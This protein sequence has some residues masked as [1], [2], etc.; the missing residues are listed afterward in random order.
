MNRIIIDYLSFTIK[1]DAKSPVVFGSK[2][3]HKFIAWV[4]GMDIADFVDCGKTR[5]YEK[6]YVC[7]DITIK[8]PFEGKEDKQGFNVVMTGNGCRH[9]ESLQLGADATKI[10]KD[11]FIKLRGLTKYGL[12]VN[13]TR[14]DNALDDFKGYLDL[15]K[16]EESMKNREYVSRF[17]VAQAIG[18]NGTVFVRDSKYVH[19]YKHGLKGRTIYFGSRNSDSFCRF[20]DKKT[21]QMQKYFNDKVRMQEL[22]AI[23]H[24][25]RMEFEFAD[26]TA[27]KMVNAFIDSEDYSKFFGAYVNGMLRFVDGDSSR[28]ERCASKS[29]WTK[30]IGTLKRTSLAIGDYKPLTLQKCR[31]YVYNNL[32]GPISVVMQSDGVDFFLKFINDTALAKIKPKHLALIGTMQEH[33]KDLCS[34]DLWSVLRP[35]VAI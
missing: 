1:V 5:F 21:E 23:E 13:I 30:F 19:N 16:I 11:F 2:L 27:L 7:N 20:Y 8:V 9:F 25:V 31:N 18:D 15:D 14:F 33:V 17:R 4:L 3:T 32:Y 29:W 12:A 24:W 34:A 26:D 28:I 6:M 10:W 22:E 35:S